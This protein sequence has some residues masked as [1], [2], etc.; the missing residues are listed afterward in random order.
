MLR[1]LSF[2]ST[3]GMTDYDYIRDNMGKSFVV[4]LEFAYFLLY[5]ALVLIQQLEGD[6]L[7]PYFIAIDPW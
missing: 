4:G 5:R 6:L 3:T 2:R 1:W 7:Y